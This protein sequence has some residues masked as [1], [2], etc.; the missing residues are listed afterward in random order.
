MKT[1]FEIPQR[2][3]AADV[4]AVLRQAEFK[5]GNLYLPPTKLDRKLYQDV[6][7]VLVAMGGAWKAGKTQA[8]V[9]LD[10]DLE[11]LEV[12]FDELKTTG[13]YTN[14]KDISFFPTPEKLANDLVTKACLLPTDRVLEPS[15]GSGA[16]A[17]AAAK[18][19]GVENVQCVEVFSPNI[20]KLQAKG[21]VVTGCDFLSLDPPADEK[22]KF[23]V[24]IMNPP[25]SNHQDVDHILHA[26]QFLN[27]T[28]RLIAV[29]SPSWQIATKSQKAESFR[30]FLQSASAEIHD[31]ASGAFKESGT[32]VATRI[33]EIE[34][35]N[36][37]WY[38]D[39]QD[40]QDLQ[41]DA[42]CADAP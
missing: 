10:A 42:A 32:L 34:A 8:H 4:L 37:P 16:L 28:G 19:V 5:D 38:Q 33:I 14:P 17:L 24:V 15:A 18:I 41:E 13:F 11:A 35:K 26:C 2:A 30:G 23:S 20:R 12:C 36:L 3:I 7:A 40:H 29:S 22:D 25:F 1:S 9:F 27:S 21:F 31:V 6:N 39:H